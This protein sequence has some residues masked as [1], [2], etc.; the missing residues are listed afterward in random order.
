MVG[1]RI[2]NV[3]KKKIISLQLAF[4]RASKSEGECVT[5]LLNVW[6]LGKKYRFTINNELDVGNIEY[7]NRKLKGEKRKLEE[8]L[9]E[10]AKQLKTEEQLK[11]VKEELEISKKTYK[12]FRDFVNKV[13]KLHRKKIQEGSTRKR[14]S[15]TTPSSTRHE[16][17]SR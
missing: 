2:L 4:K 15:R 17:V 10:T 13:A 7:E 5:K 8:S 12:K 11:T 16:Y 9:E 14:S 1:Q 3:F 6:E